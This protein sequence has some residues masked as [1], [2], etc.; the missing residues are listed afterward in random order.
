MFLFILF[1]IVRNRRV[2]AYL[3]NRFCSAHDSHLG[4]ILETDFPDHLLQCL[5]VPMHGV[6]DAL[7]IILDRQ[8]CYGREYGPHSSRQ[9]ATQYLP[10][11]RRE[12]SG[13]FLRFVPTI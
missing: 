1:L 7:L 2:A 13:A 12:S 9:R 8:F 4:Q 6:C 11:N 3:A 10:C 5:E